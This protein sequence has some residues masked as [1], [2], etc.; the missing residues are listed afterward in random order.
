MNNTDSRVVQQL[1][2]FRIV[3]PDGE[4]DVDVAECGFLFGGVSA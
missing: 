4:C 2:L 3:E 1:Q